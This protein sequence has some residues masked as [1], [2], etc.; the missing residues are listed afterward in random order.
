MFEIGNSLREARLR[1]QLDFPEI[2]QATKIRGKYLRA[3][4][5][6]QF[7]VLPAQTYVKGFLRSYSEY[8]GLDGQLY[9]DEYNSR[10]VVGEE[11][12][13]TRPRR[14][15]PP[16]SRGV[17]VQS[18]VVLLTLLGIAAVTA[19]VIVAWTRGEPQKKEPVGL[20]QTPTQPV[21][22]KPNVATSPV[23][24]IVT[25]KRGN[26]WLEVHSG[27]ATGRILFQ[28]TLERGQRK[29]FSGRKLWITLDRPENLG[30]IL[31]GRSR[32]LPAGGVKTL[33]VTARGIRAGV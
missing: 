4:E 18:R 14:S 33:I 25:G 26:C 31:N 30:T 5:D 12:A 15:A 13:P 3:L 27:S 21:V 29:L 24:L 20:G 22:V 2:E 10:F 17:Q 28:G 16:Q 32:V 9:V 6:E 23:R 11:E 8:L 1:Q 7:D 19:L